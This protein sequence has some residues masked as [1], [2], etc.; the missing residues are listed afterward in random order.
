MWRRTNSARFSAVVE[1]VG[2]EEGL[3]RRP[4]GLTVAVRRRELGE[5][6]LAHD[7]GVEQLV[8]GGAG[9]VEEEAR[10]AAQVGGIDRADHGSSAGTAADGDEALDLQQ[11][12]AL[13]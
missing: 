11:A 2:A 10:H 5:G 13:A 3:H 4:Y 8:V 1:V 12:E 9:D 6:A 7:P